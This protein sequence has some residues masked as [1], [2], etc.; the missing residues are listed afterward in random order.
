MAADHTISDASVRRRLHRLADTQKHAYDA[1]ALSRRRRPYARQG[2]GG[3][4]T[5]DAT[6]TPNAS[7]GRRP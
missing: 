1:S 7:T 3:R 5:A 6:Q 4:S 2:A